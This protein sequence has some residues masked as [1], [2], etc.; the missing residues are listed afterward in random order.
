[1]I[2]GFIGSTF[3][4]VSLCVACLRRSTPSIVYAIA[5][6]ATFYFNPFENWCNTIINEAIWERHAGTFN[7]LPDEFKAAS[8]LFRCGT[9]VGLALTLS[10]AAMAF[11]WITKTTDSL[12]EWQPVRSADGLSLKSYVSVT[13]GLFGWYCIALAYLRNLHGPATYT[14]TRF[15]TMCVLSVAAARAIRAKSSPAIVFVCVTST[16]FW[17]QRWFSMESAISGIFPTGDL[18][19]GNQIVRHGFSVLTGLAA[20]SLMQLKT[21]T[22]VSLQT[23]RASE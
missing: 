10:L 22:V 23:R 1:M 8:R 2:Y 16:L 11:E 13:L 12:A 20:A 7:R 4:A 15:I 18:H 5:I 17:L 6:V 19:T 21:T 14:V 3:V 9:N